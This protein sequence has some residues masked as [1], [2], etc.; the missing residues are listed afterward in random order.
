MRPRTDATLRAR[1]THNLTNFTLASSSQHVII[2]LEFDLIPKYKL[3]TKKTVLFG[4]Y[5]RGI[6][7]RCIIP[8]A[9]RECSF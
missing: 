1:L 7:I 8:D 9:P 6:P 5:E 4:S 2:T 3:A